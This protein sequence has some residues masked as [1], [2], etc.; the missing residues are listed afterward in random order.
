MA[1]KN[2]LIRDA[3]RMT[4]AILSEN[5]ALD[6]AES[7]LSAAQASKASQLQAVASARAAL[8]AAQQE[9]E[10][11]SQNTG[12]LTLLQGS[13]EVLSARLQ[14]LISTTKAG[15]QK[16]NAAREAAL[17]AHYLRRGVEAEAVRAHSGSVGCRQFELTGEAPVW[18]TRALGLLGEA[19]ALWRRA[20]DASHL[21]RD[22]LEGAVAQGGGWTFEEPGAAPAEAPT[23]TVLYGAL[24]REAVLGDARKALVQL[25]EIAQALGSLCAR[26]SAAGEAAPPGR[27]GGEEEEEAAAAAAAAAATVLTNEEEAKTK[28]AVARTATEKKDD[29]GKEEAG[30]RGGGR[31]GAASTGISSFVAYGTKADA[32]SAADEVARMLR[33]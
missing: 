6:G 24:G 13:I 33:T 12:E 10:R 3:A 26:C 27:G 15:R 8:A 11:E 19:S 2:A 17:Q 4:S 9:R 30:E 16:R 22:V 7:R 29:E 23:A 31:R 21:T 18:C 20:S 25:G 32:E 14:E 28:K 5:E 1:N